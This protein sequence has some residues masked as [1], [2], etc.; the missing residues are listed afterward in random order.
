[1]PAP[2]ITENSPAPTYLITMDSSIITG[3]AHLL[4]IE[5]GFVVV[6][7]TVLAI[8]LYFLTFSMLIELASASARAYRDSRGPIAIIWLLLTFSF[9][10]I[11]FVLDLL[12][13]LMLVWFGYTLLSSFRYWWHKG[14]RF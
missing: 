4:G 12:H 10:T 2:V 5:P 1:M 6:G 9:G 8:L 14:A 3:P 11:I 13:T 7:W